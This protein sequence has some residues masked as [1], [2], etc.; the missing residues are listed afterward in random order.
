MFVYMSK[1]LN[2]TCCNLQLFCDMLTRLLESCFY[3]LS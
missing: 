2:E 1:S 3:H